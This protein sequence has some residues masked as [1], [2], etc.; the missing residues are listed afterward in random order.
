MTS[1]RS[2]LFRSP[3]L[4]KSFNHTIFNNPSYSQFCRCFANVSIKVPSLGDSISEGTIQEIT[5]S[6]NSAVAADD[7]VARLETDKVVVDV[8]S[9]VKGAIKQILV[10][11]GQEVKVGEELMIVDDAAA[12]TSST[13]SK[14]Q[15]PQQIA[16]QPQQQQAQPQQYKPVEQP[17]Q[18]HQPQSS[19]S[20]A[21]YH[22]KIRFT[23]GVGRNDNGDFANYPVHSAASS[24]APQ[25]SPQKT[26]SA[27]TKTDSKTGPLSP[28][29]F[30]AVN[31]AEWRQTNEIAAKA[32]LNLPPYYRKR[33]ISLKEQQAVDMGGAEW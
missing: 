19:H 32:V 8:R 13:S 11:A 25:S 23:H 31:S 9:P 30:F 26:S 21:H 4:F 2:R 15:K 29:A 17:N 6:N 14:P 33:A 27:A 3:C 1:L 20:A 12:G 7:I 16:P 18:S 10:K 22:P 28:D 24:N 5:V